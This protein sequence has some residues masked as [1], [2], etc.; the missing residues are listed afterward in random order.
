MLINQFIPEADVDGDAH[1]PSLNV[2]TPEATSS[3]WAWPQVYFSRSCSERVI[4]PIFC[5]LLPISAD[6]W[7]RSFVAPSV[8]CRCWWV[9]SPATAATSRMPASQHPEPSPLV[10]ANFYCSNSFAGLAGDKSSG[11]YRVLYS[12]GGRLAD[13]RT[14][15]PGR[16]LISHAVAPFQALK[17]LL[18][19]ADSDTDGYSYSS[20]CSSRIHQQLSNCSGHSWLYARHG[21][22]FI[23]IFYCRWE[24]RN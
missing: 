15:P 13:A 5:E 9:W 6:K 1:G 8:T 14:L 18:L 4:S 20:V 2:F 7:R 21:K 3:S 16:V 11:R 22:V 24:P 19:A 23:A 12:A 17:L 10:T